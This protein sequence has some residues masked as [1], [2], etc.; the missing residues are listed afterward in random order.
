MTY[1][2]L[3][4]LLVANQFV[5]GVNVC[6]QIM[7]FII[8]TLNIICFRNKMTRHLKSLIFDCLSFTED[9]ITSLSTT[10]RE[11]PAFIRR[12]TNAVL[13]FLAAV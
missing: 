3:S 9:L 11:A 12:S 13:P 2:I 6:H 7:F 10:D 4:L 5:Q 1:L 8:I